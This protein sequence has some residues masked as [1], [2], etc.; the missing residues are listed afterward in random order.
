MYYCY[1]TDDQKDG[2]NL[3]CIICDQLFFQSQVGRALRYLIKYILFIRE[4][5]IFYQISLSF[6]IVHYFLF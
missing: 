6:Q 3:Y 2:A 1:V 4:R 5:N